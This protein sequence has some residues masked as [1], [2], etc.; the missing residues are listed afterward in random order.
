M[1]RSVLHFKE[2]CGLK[3]HF[4]ARFRVLHWCSDQILS[5]AL[6]QMDLT[7]SQGR[8]M[9]YLSYRTQPPCAKD[10]EDHFHL[11][12]PSVS[13]TLSRLEKKGF[14]EFRPDEADRRCKRIYLL[15]KGA[16]CHERILQTI[17]DMEKQIIS[18]FSEEEQA[19]L[20]SFLDRAIENMGIHPCKSF[21][22]EEHCQ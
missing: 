13:G 9:G 12:H 5:D 19:Q 1:I 2:V 14:I 22:K 3:Y 15:P 4:G 6:A 16:E 18:G 20:S 21:P 8:I 10:I 7:A 11:S 17:A